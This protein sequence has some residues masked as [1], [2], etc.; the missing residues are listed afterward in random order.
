MATVPI[1]E[2]NDNVFLALGEMLW[3]WELCKGCAAGQACSSSLSCSSSRM[4]KAKRYFQFYEALVLDYLQGVLES[5]RVL[6]THGDV[7]RII[8]YL[9]T[10]PDVTYS[11]LSEIICPAGHPDNS[12]EAVSNAIIL[13]VKVGTMIDCS[14]LYQ[15]PDRLEKGMSRICWRGDVPFSKYLQDLF[16]TQNH[17]VWSSPH[18]ENDVLLV[19]KSELRAPKLV[20][21]LKLKF[22]PT[23]D[24]RNHL[25]LDPRRNTLEVFHYTSFLKE[26]LR[27]TRR[28]ASGIG[29]RNI[30]GALLPRQLLLETLDSTQQILFPLHDAKAKRILNSLV[31]DQRYKFDAETGRFEFGALRSAGEENISYVYL[32]DRLEE[33]YQ[34]LQN[35]RPRSWLDGHLQRRSGARYMML[36]TLVGVLFAVL[37]GI[38]ALVLSAI[39]TWIAYEA[40]KRPIATSGV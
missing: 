27:A 28:E 26:Q 25:R 4:P 5:R 30:P 17:P 13:A 15:S 21:H 12:T 22:R 2:V 40:W 38:A 10:N 37:L 33:L 19:M 6:N 20:K 35:P 18:Q 3:S 24:I 9:K 8:E 14:A 32:A 23:H 7:F 39:Q 16:P 36:A 31:K 34:E 1:N 11:G 29:A